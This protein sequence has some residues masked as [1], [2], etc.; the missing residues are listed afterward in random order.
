ML[1]T[2]LFCLF[3]DYGLILQAVYTVS[4]LLLFFILGFIFFFSSPILILPPFLFFS[5]FHPPYHNPT[6]IDNCWLISFHCLSH[7]SVSWFFPPTES[8][9]KNLLANSSSLKI[10]SGIF[11]RI[12]TNTYSPPRSLIMLSSSDT[13]K[14]SVSVQNNHL[15]TLVI[16]EWASI[17]KVQSLQLPQIS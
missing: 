12:C 9:K 4:P 16:E 13:L 3:F 7:T 17:C 1:V 11:P 8:Q 10:V 5:L 2:T 15:L 14:Y 6:H